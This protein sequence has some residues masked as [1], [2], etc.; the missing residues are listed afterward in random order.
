MSRLPYAAKQLIEQV[1]AAR[2]SAK[3]EP[4]GEVD[5]LRVHRTIK[6]DKRTSKWLAP[7][8][9]QFADID[10]RIEEYDVTSAGYLHITF[11]STRIADDRSPYPLKAAETVSR[12]AQEAEVPEADEEE[13]E[14]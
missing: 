5:G 1:Q 4:H 14:K 9:D 6:F 7:I 11:V 8:L 13:R 3:A 10:E 12:E 2:P